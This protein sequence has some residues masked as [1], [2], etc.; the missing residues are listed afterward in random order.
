VVK[1]ALRG[2]VFLLFGAVLNG[3]APSVAT[4]GVLNGASFTLDQPITP[5]SLISVFGSNLASSLAQADSIPLSTSLGDVQSVTF[6]NVA[7]PLVYVS[8]TQINAQ[9]P[10]EVVASGTATVVVNRTSGSSLPATVQVAAFSPGIFSVQFGVGQAIVFSPEGILSAPVGS[11]PGLTTRP[12]KVGDTLIIFGTGLGSVDPMVETGKAPTTLTNVT[13][14]PVVLVGGV[15][16]TVTF[17]GLSP[18]FPGVNQVNFVVPS[19]VT[20]GDA[21]PLQFQVGGI[22]TTDKVT[23]AIS[24]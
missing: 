10:W 22:T 16:A 20:P 4:G 1:N 17:A 23:M 24:Q 18:Q 21:I 11:I 12:A 6:N 7:A 14:A 13:T 3:Q 8:P 15:Q 2:I 5:G 9:L 19:G